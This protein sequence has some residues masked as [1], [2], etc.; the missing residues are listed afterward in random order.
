MCIKQKLL[1]N[2]VF[3]LGYLAA[4]VAGIRI[5]FVYRMFYESYDASWEVWYCWILAMME[6]NIAVT[7][8][9]L[10]AVKVFFQSVG[11]QHGSTGSSTG[12]TRTWSEG[13][14]RSWS[15]KKET[16]VHIAA[17]GR[18]RTEEEIREQENRRSNDTE[19]DLLDQRGSVV[20]LKEYTGNEGV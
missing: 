9:S 7:C 20:E 12:K 4:V 2:V 15:W 1:L 3:G 17:V 13:R 8:S 10:P 5:Y 6:V 14:S 18:R 16:S 19:R 11:S